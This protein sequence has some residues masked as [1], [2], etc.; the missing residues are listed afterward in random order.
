[1]FAQTPSHQEIKERHQRNTN[2]FGFLEAIDEALTMKT[3]E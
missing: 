2:A 3:D 1:M